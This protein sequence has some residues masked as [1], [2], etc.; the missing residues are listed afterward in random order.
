[1][2]KEL[3]QLMCDDVSLDDES[4]QILEKVTS[5]IEK[6]IRAILQN[7]NAYAEK[8]TDDKPGGLAWEM[9]KV[10]YYEEELTKLANDIAYP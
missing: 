4:L 9:T 2:L 3:N 10:R 5:E 1:M 6:R 8:D 7:S